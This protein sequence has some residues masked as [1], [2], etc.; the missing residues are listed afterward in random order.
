MKVALAV[1]HAG[2]V[3]SGPT[4]SVL[5]LAE[6]LSRRGI[7]VTLHASGAQACAGSSYRVRLYSDFRFARGLNW[8]LGMWRGLLEDCRVADVVH[9]NGL[10]LLA[11]LYPAW[12]ARRLRKPLVIAPRGN[13]SGWAMR[14]RSPRKRLMWALAQRKVLEHATCVHA[15]SDE[16]Y[17]A[18]RAAGI[19]TPV[20]I[21]PNGVDVPEGD[22]PNV[23]SS[24]RRLLFLARL[25]PVKGLERL[26]RSWAR[27]HVHFPTWELVIAGPDEGGY[28]KRMELLAEE[29]RLPR[30]S[31]R[32]EVTGEVK[33]R[34]YFAASCYVLPT[35][36]E[37][38]GVTIAEALAHGVPAVVTQGAPW[39]GLLAERC[40]WW[41]EGTEEALDD[42]LRDAMSRPA[43]V[44]GEMGARGRA[45][46]LRDFS[47]SSAAARMF[48][49]YL[50]CC[51]RGPAPPSLRVG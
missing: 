12:A 15:T 42:A 6:A 35:F 40:G 13:L 36:T 47:W 1:P 29:L 43:H 41:V 45:W 25:H 28:G 38:F 4:Y 50:W 18:V 9:A 49:I 23:R 46:M 26:L 34:E 16:E 7:D 19:R 21:V 33:S 14:F 24:P 10:W 37:N 3:S 48:E 39:R 11:A 5:S 30:I 32:G 17:E 20:G 51:G 44:L 27:L 22:P 2:H 31:F 8:P